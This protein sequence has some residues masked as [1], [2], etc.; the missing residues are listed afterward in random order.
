MDWLVFY[1][2]FKKKIIPSLYNLL[3]NT[4]VEVVLPNTFSGSTITLIPKLDKD[5]ARKEKYSRY[6]S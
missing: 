6:L 1:Q 2:I 3:W 5:I 4:E